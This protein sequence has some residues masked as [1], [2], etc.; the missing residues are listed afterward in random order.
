MPSFRTL[1][2]S[3]YVAFLRPV[4]HLYQYSP[5]HWLPVHVAPKLCARKA[6]VSAVSAASLFSEAENGVDGTEEEEEDEE[7]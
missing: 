1:H 3:T 4:H 2:I 7:V 6:K 5:L